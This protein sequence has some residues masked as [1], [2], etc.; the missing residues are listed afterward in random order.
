VDHQ[1]C[2]ALKS[3]A[4][5]RRSESR[6]SDNE[7]YQ[8]TPIQ[9]MNSGP[10]EAKKRPHGGPD[11]TE[12]T[13]KASRTGSGPSWDETTHR[14]FVSAV[15]DVGM[16]HAS[17]AIILENMQSRPSSITSERVK[18]HLQKYRLNRG[19]GKDEFMSG[20]D[21]WMTKA[22]SLSEK[23]E[24]STG[25][26]FAANPEFILD[27]MSSTLPVPGDLAAFISFS[28]MMETKCASDPATAKKWMSQEECEV[29]YEESNYLHQ[30][31]GTPITF[32]SLS[33][34]EKVSTLGK[35]MCYV[36]AL[37]VNM[38]EH[39]CKMRGEQ[40][41]SDSQDN[42]SN[43]DY[44]GNHH[45]VPNLAGLNVLGK[46]PETS[47]ALNH[48]SSHVAD[49]M[50]SPIHSQ[51]SANYTHFHPDPTNKQN[52]SEFSKAAGDTAK[53]LHTNSSVSPHAHHN[54]YRLANEFHPPY[55]RTQQV[56]NQGFGHEGNIDHQNSN[57]NYPFPFSLNYNQHFQSVDEPHELPRNRD[58]PLPQVDADFSLWNPPRV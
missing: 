39:L 52:D 44:Q 16:K 25:S 31:N 45:E 2:E 41:D 56:H 50:E 54:H 43:S 7:K 24:S 34:E 5:L 19:K 38:T 10:S 12:G 51:T 53:I 32:P 17:P 57:S 58:Q 15:Y 26:R 23:T 1:R 6:V 14:S 33:E 4:G 20:Y 22:L 46:I 37:F 11:G 29:A 36:L 48:Q 18:S 21:N 8:Y 13:D 40:V 9:G 27:M 42:S 28:I 3:K 30:F 49:S 35:G 47:T 55:H